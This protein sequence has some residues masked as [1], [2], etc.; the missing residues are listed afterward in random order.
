[1][2]AGRGYEE[3][4]GRRAVLRRLDEKWMDCCMMRK[5]GRQDSNVM[6]SS[7]QQVRALVHV[8]LSM[9]SNSR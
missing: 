8:R 3:V 6:Y 2:V 7:Y 1:M 4:L 9:S 5:G